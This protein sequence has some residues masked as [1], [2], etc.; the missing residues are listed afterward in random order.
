MPHSIA[1]LPIHPLLVHATVVIV[2]AAALAVL[3]AA[4]WRRFRRWS[5]PLPLAL[6]V[7]GLI[8]DPLSTSS[9]ESLE[10]QVGGSTLIEKH[11]EL[12]DGLLPWMIAL[13][14]GAAG[15]YAWHWRQDRRGPGAVPASQRWVPVAISVLAVVAALGTTVQVVL[16]GHSGAKAAWSRPAAQTV[17]QGPV[18]K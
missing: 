1:G 3:L 12:A 14:A 2:P 11:A 17:E 16:I 4:V 13:V 5:G 10:H 6:A 8:L 9:G 15:L 18:N 7:L